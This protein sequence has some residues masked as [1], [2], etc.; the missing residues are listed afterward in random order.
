MT[1]SLQETRELWSLSGHPGFYSSARELR[2][3]QS[4]E[5]YK[6][7]IFL[8]LFFFC[9]PSVAV[10][11]DTF[12]LHVDSGFLENTRTLSSGSVSRSLCGGS[13]EGLASTLPCP[14]SLTQKDTSL[15]ARRN[16]YRKRCFTCQT[17]RISASP[18]WLSH[19]FR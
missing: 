7:V 16:E 17:P 14:P 18:Q 4:S 11:H 10:T 19:V 8:F 12:S 6:R 2:R 3:E 13:M 1:T 9:I 5:Y 15:Q